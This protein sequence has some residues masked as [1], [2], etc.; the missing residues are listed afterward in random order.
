MKEFSRVQRVS[1][2]IQRELAD[3]IQREMNHSTIGILTISAVKL[4]PDLKWAQIYVTCLGNQVSNKDVIKYL[5]DKAKSL[6]HHLAQRLTIRTTPQLQF[7]Y[8]ESIEYGIRLSR[9]IDS[10]T[11]DVE[12]DVKEPSTKQ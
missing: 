11:T 3:I 10:V 12:T 2:L 8:D 9:L 1:V 4:S 7:V 6:R 5:N